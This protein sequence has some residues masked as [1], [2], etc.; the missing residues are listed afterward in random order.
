MSGAARFVPKL[1]TVVVEGWSMYPAYADG[2]RLLARQSAGRSRP[3]T[4]A[5]SVVVVPRPCEHDDWS[6]PPP[7]GSMDFFVKR[8]R[9][10]PS[11]VVPT[12][13]LDAVGAN[14]GD[15]V[16]PGMLLIIGDHPLSRDSKQHGYCPAD[17]VVAVV[18]RRLIRSRRAVPPSM[19]SA[20]SAVSAVPDIL[21]QDTGLVRARITQ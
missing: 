14:P 4:P 9:A 19:L 8:V 11:D 21:K 17:L 18:V 15:R 1:I 16:P 7:P 3:P 5:G 20:L 6:K 12:G 13:L 2:D 10:S